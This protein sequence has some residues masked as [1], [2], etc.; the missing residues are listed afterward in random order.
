MSDN[1]LPV[2]TTK[3][4]PVLLQ[5]DGKILA[6]SREIALHFEKRHDHVLASIDALISHSPILGDGTF[7]ENKVPHPVISGRM[8]RF[9]EMNRDGFS[10]L[11]MGFTGSRA[12]KWKI[13]YITAFNLME[14]AFRKVPDKTPYAWMRAVVDDMEAQDKRLFSVE[15]SV[16]RIE[17]VVD[18]LGGHED[19][20]SIKRYAAH[21]GLRLSTAKSSE[22]GR[23][24]TKLTRQRKMKMGT[25]P[26]ETYDHVNTYHRDILAEVFEPLLRETK[27]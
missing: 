22:L 6:D 19:F 21:K 4:K 14:D 18:N 8:D 3:G 25:Q 15:K 17:K 27:P 11:A 10:L 26:D 9:F 23:L 2:S 13:D 1:N 24:A 20:M 12:L 5:H 16:E 7:I